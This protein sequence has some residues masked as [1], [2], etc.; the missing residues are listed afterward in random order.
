MSMCGMTT[1]VLLLLPYHAPCAPSGEAVPRLTVSPTR[2]RARGNTE[3]P[4]Y[5]YASVSHVTEELEGQCQLVRQ[6]SSL[7]ITRLQYVCS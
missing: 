1:C 3:Q 4:R 6:Y 5:S 7:M 2:V